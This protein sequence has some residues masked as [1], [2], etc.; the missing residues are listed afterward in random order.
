[1]E[2]IESL[3]ENSVRRPVEKITNGVFVSDHPYGVS[4]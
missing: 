1:M 4:G 2:K 3:K